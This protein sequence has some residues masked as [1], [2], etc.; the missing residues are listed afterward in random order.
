MRR[1]RETVSKMQNY[2][3]G[4]IIALTLQDLR[5]TQWDELNQNKCYRR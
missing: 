1:K 4:E 5:K 3:L 2:T